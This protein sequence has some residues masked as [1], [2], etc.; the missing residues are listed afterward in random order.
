[1]PEQAICGSEVPETLS[2]P[3]QIISQFYHAFNT[4]DINL[5]AENWSHSDSISM[6]NPAGGLKKG[7]KEIKEIY[8]HIF[9]E[10][11]HY[12]LELTDYQIQQSAEMFVVSG[13]VVGTI[14]DKG[15]KFTVQIRSTRIYEQEC[16]NWKQIHHH[17]SIINP[18]KLSE[19]QIAI[20]G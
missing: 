7:W 20:L 3:E 15:Q 10:K 13:N 18:S 14:E 4:R 5:M 19:Y 9:G 8:E 1:M 12:E 2:K 11:F 16:G 17:G 6:F